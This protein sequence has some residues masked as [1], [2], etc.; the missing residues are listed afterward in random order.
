M[1]KECNEINNTRKT[2][3]MDKTGLEPIETT[4][5][6]TQNNNFESVETATDNKKG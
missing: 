6:S 4:D 2:K 5:K 3:E 1:R